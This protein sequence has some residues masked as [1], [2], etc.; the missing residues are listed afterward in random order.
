MMTCSSFPPSFFLI[1]KNKVTIM[2]VIEISIFL[3]WKKVLKMMIIIIFWMKR[4]ADDD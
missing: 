1:G 2:F 3:E 4:A